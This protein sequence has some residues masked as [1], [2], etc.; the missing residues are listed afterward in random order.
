MNEKLELF[1]VSDAIID[2]RYN[3]SHPNVC[4]YHANINLDLGPDH[5]QYR[6]WAPEVGDISRYT[7]TQWLGDG[8]YSDVFS[9]LQDGSSVVAIKVLK[10][11]RGVRV[12]REVK[13]LKVLNGHP[14]I[15]NLIDFVVDGRNGIP[16]I[17]MNCAKSRPW[18]DLFSSM[19]MDDIRLYLFR[20]LEALAHTHSHGIMHRDVKPL[21]IMCYDP[22]ESVVLGDWGLSE[23]YHPTQRYTTHVGTSYYKAP[24]ILLGY[25]FYD[26]GVDVWAA[27][28]ILLELLTHKIHLFDANTNSR[29]VRQIAEILGGQTFIDYAARYRIQLSTKL[30]EKLRACEP[31]PL[32]N[33]IP[34]AHRSFRDA[35]ALDLVQKMLVVDHKERISAEEALEHRFF[36]AVRDSRFKR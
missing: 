14:G 19:N 15:T 3:P 29:I 7:L 25:E 1:D 9:G 32:E 34:Y 5:W 30:T 18:R 2:N 12:R 27:G 28:V 23:F 35:D 31:I 8:R 16:C 22:A 4:R 6:Q 13:I 17:V 20:L 36:D 10:P 33:T 26:Y 11:I 24:E 21:N